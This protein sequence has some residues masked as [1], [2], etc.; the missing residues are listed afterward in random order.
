MN[1]YITV[2]TTSVFAL[3]LHL[4][5]KCILIILQVI[6]NILIFSINYIM[7]SGISRLDIYNFIGFF[8]FDNE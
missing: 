5:L 3:F 6:D 7:I 4:I 8:D 1:I 2:N